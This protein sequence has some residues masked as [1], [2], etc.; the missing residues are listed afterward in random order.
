[1]FKKNDVIDIHIDDLSIE[2]A[3]IGKHNGFT[4]F[5]PKALPGETIHAKIIKVK[6]SYAVARLIKIVEYSE[7]R[8]IPFCKVFETC[9]GCT[10]QHLDY[11]AQITFKSKHIKD[12]FKRLGGIDITMPPIIEADNIRDYRNKA[13]FAVS[14]IDGKVEAGFYVPR[15]HRLVVSDCPIQKQLINNIKNVIVNW[16]NNKGV[17]AYDEVK[18]TGTLRHIIGRQASEGDLMAGIVARNN[19]VDKSLI[20]ALNDIQELKSVVE[21]INIRETNVILGSENRIVYGDAYITEKYEDLS[22][23]VGLTSFLQ[24]NHE[25]SKKLYQTALDFANISKE[26]TVFDLFCGIGTI[27]LLAAKRAKNVLGIEYVQSAVD[28]AKENAKSNG[29]DNAMFLAGD[30]G[31]MIDQVIKD[32]GKPDIIILDPPR[33]GCEN[34]LINKIVVTCPKKV[35]YLSCN[36]ATLAR[37]VSLFCKHGYILSDVRGVDM[38]PHTTHVECVV[39]MSRVES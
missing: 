38:F 34:I 15:S 24:I 33:K 21:N 11:A 28:N 18:K 37:D 36:P 9:G 29:I 16:A 39:L 10:L 20:S 13:S 7:H 22:F 23:G 5:I 19:V 8:I 6:K 17:S 4:V 27:S 14:E 25:Q 32:V 26:D 31:Q 30:A 1:M 35:V 12:C 2:G 3:G